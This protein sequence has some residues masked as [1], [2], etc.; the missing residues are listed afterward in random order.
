MIYVLNALDECK[1]FDPPTIK[2]NEDGSFFRETINERE[3][4]IN[5]NTENEK[6]KDIPSECKEKAKHSIL[7]FILKTLCVKLHNMPILDEDVKFN[8]RCISLSWIK[9]E[10]LLIS[11]EIYDES[12]FEKI[13]EHIKNIDNLRTPEEMLN[14]LALAVQL[15]NSLFIFMLNKTDS[16]ADS[17]A[18]ILIYV[19]IMARPKKMIFNLKFI[20]FFFDEKNKM[21]KLEYNLTQAKTSIAFIM[22]MKG[23]DLNLQEEEFQKK[24]KETS[25]LEKTNKK[26]APLP[27]N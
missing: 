17:F 10:N 19:I 7:N 26:A 21:G 4:I 18:A 22:G 8:E 27:K 25:D 1:I 2:N 23:K 6:P 5:P 15:I 24:C 12:I 13:I 14:E 3:S 16:D 11:N 9:P 20:E